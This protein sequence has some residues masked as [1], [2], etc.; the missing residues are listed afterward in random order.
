MST[1]LKNG[2]HHASGAAT[3]RTA[4]ATSYHSLSRQAGS[5]FWGGVPLCMVAVLNHPCF[6]MMRC[7]A[8]VCTRHDACARS[9]RQE[10]P[11]DQV[12]QR[13]RCR[14]SCLSLWGLHGHALKGVLIGVVWSG[15]SQGWALCSLRQHA[16]C[17]RAVSSQSN[18]ISHGCFQAACVCGVK[19]VPGG[20][21]CI[22]SAG[23]AD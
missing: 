10:V 11:S 19:S 3:S 4:V 6:A 5:M 16:R 14:V 15:S 23:L 21:F 2:G 18:S 9:K 7:S 22:Q 17:S 1:C 8:E 20:L 13:C 12:E